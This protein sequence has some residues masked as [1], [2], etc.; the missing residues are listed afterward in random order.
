MKRR[1]SGYSS[2]HYEVEKLI[3]EITNLL[4]RYIP[5]KSSTAA[6]I[7]FCLFCCGCDLFDNL[8][9][10][11]RGAYMERVISLANVGIKSAYIANIIIQQCWKLRKNWWEY[12]EEEQLD[13]TFAI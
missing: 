10:S 1:V 7:I 8:C 11:L 2:N 3:Q 5:P 13:I 4:I 6:C 12:L 9:L